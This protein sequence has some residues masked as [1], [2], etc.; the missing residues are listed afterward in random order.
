MLLDGVNVALI[1]GTNTE[2]SINTVNNQVNTQFYNDNDPSVNAVVPFPNF[3]ADGFTQLFTAM[4]PVSSTTAGGHSLKLVI[5]DSS[6][7]IYD[8]WVLIQGGSLGGIVVNPN[9]GGDPHFK[10]VAG[11]F[12]DF[13]GQC[14]LVFLDSPV[15]DLHI[16]IRT[17]VRYDYSYIE[18]AVVRIGNSTLEVG[19][20][21][22]FA[23]DG[24]SVTHVEDQTVSGF[25]I[26]YTKHTDKH[27]TFDIVV[28][29]AMNVTLGAFKVRMCI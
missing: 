28:S 11:K 8:S 21:G 4:G 23:L 19:A 27:S 17:T 12:F 9:T 20:Y 14:D 29:P 7:C 10:T 22:D 24:I 3:E 15:M 18:S 26:I 13:H 6:D 2:V 25:P 1:P 5:A 16:D